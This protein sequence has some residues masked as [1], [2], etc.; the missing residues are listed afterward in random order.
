M[1]NGQYFKLIRITLFECKSSS[2]LITVKAQTTTT[3]I[4]VQEMDFFNYN[5]ERRGYW[6]NIVLRILALKLLVYSWQSD[7]LFYFSKTLQGHSSYNTDER[8]FLKVC[9]NIQLPCTWTCTLTL[10]LKINA[11][12][13]IYSNL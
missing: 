13:I 9:S 8:K 11:Y 6:K 2:F 3:I 1:L 7:K 4:N 12:L 5:S 10:S